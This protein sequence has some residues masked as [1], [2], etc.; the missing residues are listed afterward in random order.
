MAEYSGFE[1]YDE[2]KVHTNAELTQLVDSK[3]RILYSGLVNKIN[4]HRT[5]QLRTLVITDKY[6][7]N[8]C[9]S[10]HLLNNISVFF[11]QK[12]AIKRQILLNKISEITISIHP[13]SEQFILHVEGEYDYR[14]DGGG[15]REKIIDAIC[16]SFFDSGKK[17]FAFNLKEVEDLA[18]F[19]TTD[20]DFKAKI[21]KRPCLGKVLVTRQLWE[22]GLDH[23]IKNRN[24]FIME[25]IPEEDDRAHSGVLGKATAMEIKKDDVSR[26]YMPNSPFERSKP[27]NSLEDIPLAT[28]TT[29]PQRQVPQVTPDP[30]ALRALGALRSQAMFSDVIKGSI[31]EIGRAHV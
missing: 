17:I 21:I 7:Y 25:D 14:Y 8:I 13:K 31:E 4:K 27:V 15:K 16:Q 6:L 3:E 26:S 22:K 9:L 30:E 20:D 19:H 12:S 10:G 1:M 18:A 2:L 23:I 11:S 29:I 5:S 28:S 24:S